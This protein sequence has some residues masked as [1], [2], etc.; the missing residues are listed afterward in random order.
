MKCCKDA[1]KQVEYGLS[2]CDWLTVAVVLNFSF[3]G[4]KIGILAIDC[5]DYATLGYEVTLRGQHRNRRVFGD[6]II[7]DGAVLK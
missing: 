4:G 5:E 1:E 3:H 6:K 2:P 7:V